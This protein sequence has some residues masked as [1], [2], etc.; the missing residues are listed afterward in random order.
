[1]N[2]C[3]WVPTVFLENWKTKMLFNFQFPKKRKLKFNIKFQFPI[4]KKNEIKIWYQFSILNFHKKWKLK[5]RCQFSYFNFLI[6][7]S[8]LVSYFQMRELE[9][10]PFFYKIEKRKSTSIFN[11]QFRKNKLKF[12]IKFQ[13]PIPKKNEN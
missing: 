3:T 10:Q 13:F 4:P 9:C 8:V 1:M 12:N 7:T 5:F 11:V 6:P 2:A